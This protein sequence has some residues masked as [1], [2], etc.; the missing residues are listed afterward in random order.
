MRVLIVEDEASIAD[1]L[2]RG[3]TE[4]GYAVDVA[5]DGDEALAWVTAA[6]YD[7]IVLDRML[8][9][10]DG[11]SVCREIRGRG[12]R[13]PILMLTARDTVDDRV[14]G[15]DAGADDYLV[16]P[17]A[18]AEVL[19]RLRA[20]LRR[21]PLT[22]APILQVGD[23]AIDTATQTVQRGSTPITLT[24]KEYSLLEYMARHANRVLTR[25][26]I[27]EH[28][29]DYSFD[30][31][32]N[33]IDVHIRALRRKIDEPFEQKLIHTVRGSGYRLGSAA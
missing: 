8:P 6:P 14:A 17:F 32:T 27:A 11:L 13:M 12:L 29:W 16:K 23:L 21:E 20:L 28:V 31:I 24:S 2:R 18:F 4:S 33:V 10:R 26:M 3:L 5:E 1:F 15:L 9:R 25:E 22:H 30:N 19:A 7:V